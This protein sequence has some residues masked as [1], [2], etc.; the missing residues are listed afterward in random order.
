M[1]GIDFQQILA[2]LNAQKQIQ[3]FT[4]PPQSQPAVAPNLA[5][6]ISQFANQNQQAAQG[7]SQWQGSVYEDPER[8]RRRE[9]GGGYDGAS[10]DAYSKRA[11][12]NGDAKA[13]KVSSA[14][15]TILRCNSIANCSIFS[16][17]RLAWFLAGFGHK[18][19][20]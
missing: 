10:D 12:M 11:K 7:Q 20:A 4:Q 5:A 9:A 2:I 1:Q 18:G 16:Q 14:E 3:Q 17:N 13:K 15:T 6:V 19:T 8:K